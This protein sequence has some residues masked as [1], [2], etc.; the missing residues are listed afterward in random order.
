MVVK[1]IPLVFFPV[2]ASFTVGEQDIRTGRVGRFPRKCAADGDLSLGAVEE[3]SHHTS[4]GPGEKERSE[5]SR[6]EIGWR[7]WKN[8]QAIISIN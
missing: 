8:G 7:G 4:S 2:Q 6:W 1:W 3:G 5:W